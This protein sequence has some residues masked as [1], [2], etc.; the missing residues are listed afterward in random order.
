MING[1]CI[2]RAAMVINE[3]SHIGVRRSRYIG[4]MMEVKNR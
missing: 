2:Y 1:K 3:K 4:V